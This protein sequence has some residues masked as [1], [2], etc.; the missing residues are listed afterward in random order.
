MLEFLNKRQTIRNFSDQ[1]IDDKL[2]NELFQAAFRSSTT[3][4]MQLYSVVKTVKEANKTQLAKH[5]FNQPVSLAAPML[6]TFCADFNRFKLWCAQRNATP[7]YDNFL[8]FMTAAIDTIIATQTFSIAAEAK[9][10]G[11]CYLG[12][13]IYLAQPIID[14]LGL[15]RGVVPITSLALGYP[16]AAN[17]PPQTD[18]LPIEAFIHEE[19]YN[20]YSP[21]AIDTIYAHKESLVENKAFVAENNKETLAQVYTDVRYKKEDNEQ[22]SA[23]LLEVLRKQGFLND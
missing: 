6:L 10:L 1:N 18:R 22:F 3:G 17:T 9:G 8:S 13:T 23:A 14:C 4:N 12:T 2:L 20:N 7:G 11:I 5:H 21:E 19:R 16:D 15:P